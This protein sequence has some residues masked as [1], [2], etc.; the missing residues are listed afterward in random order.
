MMQCVKTD[1]SGD[2]I[3]GGFD[4][5]LSFCRFDEDWSADELE[6]ASADALALASAA[7]PSITAAARERETTNLGFEAF[8]FGAFFDDT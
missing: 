6:L 3:C 4:V 1:R 7:P 8:R 5:P 2:W